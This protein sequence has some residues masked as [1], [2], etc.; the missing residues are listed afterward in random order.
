[1]STPVSIPGPDARLD[2]GRKLRNH[3]QQIEAPGFTVTIT[4]AA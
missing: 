3:I 4:P 1:V 2:T